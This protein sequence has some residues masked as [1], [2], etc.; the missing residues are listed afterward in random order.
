M[1]QYYIAINTDTMEWIQPH[2][3]DNGAKLME[4]SYLTNN[5]VETVEF[6]LLDDGE[7]KSRWAG[8]RIVW[9]GDYADPEAKEGETLYESSQDKNKL[10]MLIEAIPPNYHYLVNWDRQ[11]FV[12][13]TRCKPINGNW[14]VNNMRVHPLPLLTAEGNGRGG[15]DYHGDNK[16]LVGTWAR[17]RISVMKEPPI[18]FTEIIPNFTED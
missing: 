15:G 16:E 7:D 9:A 17:D 13:K 2:D 10:G 4:H 5:F 12:D 18:G 8:Q 1:G 14:N 11:E 6:L 3:F